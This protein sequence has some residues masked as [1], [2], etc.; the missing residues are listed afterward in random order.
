MPQ[1]KFCC[2]WIQ[3]VQKY[4]KLHSIKICI[5]FEYL[6]TKLPIEFTKL[7]M[8]LSSCPQ[9]KSVLYKVMVSVNRDHVR[10]TSISKIMRGTNPRHEYHTP[11]TDKG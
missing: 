10:Y 7:Q 1:Y 5:I 11:E 2:F 3:T 6:T 9:C 4:I 8:A